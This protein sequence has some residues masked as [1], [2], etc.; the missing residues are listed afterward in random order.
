MRFRIKLV[1]DARPNADG[2]WIDVIKD[3]EA[4]HIE[5]FRWSD[6]ETFFHSD[7]PKGEHIVQYER[8]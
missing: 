7:T 8:A 6:I 5:P 2:R 3:R 1:P 4:P